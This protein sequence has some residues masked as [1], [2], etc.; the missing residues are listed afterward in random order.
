MNSSQCV[1][2]PFKEVRWVGAADNHFGVDILN[3]SFVARSMVATTS[4]PA[5]AGR[6]GKL[7][8]SAGEAHRGKEPENPVASTCH[9]QYPCEGPDLGNGTLFLADEMEDK[10]DIFQYEGVLYFARSWTGDLGYTAHVRLKSSLAT[11][12]K[13]VARAE[14]VHGDLEYAVC[15]VDFLIKSHAYFLAVPHPLPKWVPDE[16]RLL[17]QFSFSQYG[18]WGLYGTRSNVTH[19]RVRKSEAGEYDFEV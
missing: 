9:L 3:C 4:D 2:D 7:R 16:P 11:V 13:V 15:A 5:I 10:W 18:R 8:G 6:F 17:G 19:F 14:W 12:S 1:T